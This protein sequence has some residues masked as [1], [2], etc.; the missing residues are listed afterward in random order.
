MINVQFPTQILQCKAFSTE[1]N[2]RD[3]M[4]LEGPAREGD[5]GEYEE[6]LAFKLW[7]A[8]PTHSPAVGH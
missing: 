1:E 6:R 4:S 5:M 7:K 3:A 2:A 8:M